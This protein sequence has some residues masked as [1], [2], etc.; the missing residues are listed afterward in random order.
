MMGMSSAEWSRYMHDVDRARGAAGGD[1]RRGRA[2][3]GGGLPRARSR[4]SRAP[5]RRSRALAARWPLGLASSSNRELIDLVLEV[6]GLDR[7]FAATVSSEEVAARE[8]GAGRLPGGRAAPGRRAGAL[9][10]DRGLGERHPQ[11]EGGRD[12][13]A[14]DPEPAVPAGRRRARRGRRRP[15]LGRRADARRRSIRSSPSRASRPTRPSIASIV[16]RS[17]LDGEQLPA[18]AVFAPSRSPSVSRP[19]TRPSWRAQRAQPV[20]ELIALR[21]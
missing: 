4:S 7:L 11:R 21:S 5:S 6:S 1:Q 17:S 9:R 2:A 12:A 10:G 8:A 13:R 3:H 14:R 15:R 16:W 20:G 18:M 19:S